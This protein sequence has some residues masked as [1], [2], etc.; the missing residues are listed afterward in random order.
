MNY[1]KILV[2][3]LTIVWILAVLIQQIYWIVTGKSNGM[4]V[5]WGIIMISIALIIN[6]MYSKDE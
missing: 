5:I 4:A 1:I 2:D 3:I 6:K